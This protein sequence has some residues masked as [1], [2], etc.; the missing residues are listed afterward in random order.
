MLFV[1]KHLHDII[2]YLTND[3]LEPYILILEQKLLSNN[4]I[5]TCKFEFK[6]HQEQAHKLTLGL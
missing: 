5:N 1:L 6:L 2:I 3:I 4:N